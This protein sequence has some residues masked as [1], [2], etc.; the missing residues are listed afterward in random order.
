M[1]KLLTTICCTELEGDYEINI[2]R[3]ETELHE[4]RKVNEGD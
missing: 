4:A 3:W 2:A 1:I